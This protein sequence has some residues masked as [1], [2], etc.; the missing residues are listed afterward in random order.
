MAQDFKDYRKSRQKERILWKDRKRIL[1][2]PISFT[3]YS[4]TEDRLQVKK[5]FFNTSIDDTLLYRI[6]DVEVKR[7]FGQKI[8]GV[9][10]VK[11]YS[12]DRTT[13]VL[14]L[15]NIRKAYLVSDFLSDLVE[16]IKEE[17]RITGREMFGTGAV[18][19][20]PGDLDG[21]GIPDVGPYAEQDGAY[22]IYGSDY[23][24]R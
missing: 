16:K 12:A 7:S 3:R 14:E 21:D 17:K 24:P 5:G 2:M 9:G 20:V 13:P 4:I 1:G 8:L 23:D 11:V 19:G 10:T 18:A 15:R 22:N 6:L